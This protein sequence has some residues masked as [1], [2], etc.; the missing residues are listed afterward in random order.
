MNTTLA[1][2]LAGGRG[3]RMD[4]LCDV[5]P[6]P[7][8]PF[9]GRFRVIDFTL[10]NCVHSN[11]GEVGVIT[12]YQRSYLSGY[13]TRWHML[14]ARSLNFRI[15]EPGAGSSYLGTADAVYRNLGHVRATDPETVLVLAGD[16]IYKMDYT[17]MIAA[18]HRN[19]ADV[20]VG[21]IRVPADQAYRFGTV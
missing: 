8:L 20:T 2:I 13:L 12:D 14:N 17:E 7:A 18:H 16:H 10:S 4:M 1:L 19:G 5:R 15:L 3:K 6:K 11:I 21:V 9:A